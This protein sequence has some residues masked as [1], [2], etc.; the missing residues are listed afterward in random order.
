MSDDSRFPG[1]VA[2]PED[3]ERLRQTQDLLLAIAENTEAVVF[4]KDLEG[5]YTF[6]NRTCAELWR[7]AREEIV[8]KT[9]FDLFPPDVAEALR[10]DDRRVVETAESIFVEEETVFHGRRHVFN[11]SKVPLFDADGHVYAI[12]GVA[13][14]MTEHRLAAEALLEETRRLETLNDLGRTLAGEL[15]RERLVQAVV[16]AGRDLSGAA[17][18]AFFYTV[19]SDAGEV[20]QLYALSGADISDFESFGMPR[21]TAV[22]GPTM[23]GE[24]ILRVD[25]ILS[26]PRYG[27]NAPH[28][29]MPEGHL[30]VR[31]YL[32]VPV[33]TRGGQVFGGLI[34]GHPDEGVFDQGAEDMVTNIAGQA[35]VALEAARAYEA[36][37][38]E[39]R[40]RAAIEEELQHAN[41]QK[42]EFLAVLGHELR[43]PI[44]TLQNCVEIMSLLPD[45]DAA[46]R[47]QEMIGRQLTQ[48]TRLVD[49]LLDVGR[50]A[51]GRF[52]VTRGPIDLASVVRSV[53]DDFADRFES[54][55]L[56]FSLHLPDRAIWVDGDRARLGQAIGNLLDNA[57]KYTPRSGTVDIRV[58]A[59]E[60]AA[61]IEVV[62]SGIGFAD[63]AMDQ[64]FEPFQGTGARDGRDGLG[65][66]LAIVR[67]ITERHDGEVTASSG[68]PNRG[69]TLF[70]RLPRIDPPRPQAHTA[71]VS[72]PPRRARRR[73]LV[74]DDNA[75][76]LQS[77]ADVLG[78]WGHDVLTAADGPTAIDTA[79][80]T[81]LD[82][83]LCDID[84]GEEMDG[85]RVARKLRSLDATRDLC[86]VAVTGFGQDSD[87]ERALNSGFDAHIVKPVD[88]VELGRLLESL[89]PGDC[90]DGGEEED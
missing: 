38:R 43:N 35:S 67:E 45:S 30:P 2:N 34:F 70:L 31:S 68:G 29:G 75:G 71:D 54:L 59:E 23:R 7:L 20:L 32:A 36:T 33:S 65:L 81:G 11:A 41:R 55:G 10:S 86:L 44:G 51:T 80:A 82:I 27:N 21:A 56:R 73:I 87:R 18:A 49:D 9:D 62:D 84:L 83:I 8:G 42:D 15:D 66:G 16:D 89:D 14:E 28:S 3:S 76:F 85:Y 46:A 26:D 13:T 48:L 6:V 24:A 60:K 53:S 57:A 50:I 77:L 12:C 79:M 22:F 61:L 17:F 69:A 19:E 25:D 90:D 37:Q 1:S 39:I 58:V 72:H 74:I 40:R 52:R 47:S 4:C 63:D 5:R 78:A 88:F 64:M